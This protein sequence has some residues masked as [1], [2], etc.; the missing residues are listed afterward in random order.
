MFFHQLDGKWRDIALIIALLCGAA[1]AASAQEKS[2]EGDVAQANNPLAN[3]TAFNI[4]NYAIGE[5][6]ETDKA[7]NQLWARVAKPFSLGQTNWLMRASL[8]VNTYPVPPGMDHQT[9]LGDA[10]IF[11]A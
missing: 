10:N 3:F 7:A 6:T 5:L 11:A 2:A 1:C 9:G 8:P 4:H